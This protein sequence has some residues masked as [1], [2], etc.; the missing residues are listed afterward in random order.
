VNPT[1]VIEW[2]QKKYRELAQKISTDPREMAML[3]ERA[4]KLLAKYG[5]HLSLEVLDA[6]KLFIQ[7]LKDISTGDYK[8]YKKRTVIKIVMALL[9][10][11]MP[12]DLIPD[13][14]LG[15]GLIDDATVILWVYKGLQVE[16]ECYREWKRAKK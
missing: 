14:I 8:D 15:I 16:L 12:L 4:T 9:Y 5:K 3:A 2:A 13:F 6:L 10:F 11:I 7:M 1:E